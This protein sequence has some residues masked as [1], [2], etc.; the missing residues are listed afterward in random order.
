MLHC[1][2]NIK[3]HFAAGEVQNQYIAAQSLGV[4]YSLYTCFPWVERKVF[5][6]PN[7]P[8]MPLCWQKENSGTLIPQFISQTTKHTIQDSGL[9]T[10]MFGSQKSVTKDEKLINRWYDGLVEFTLNHGA[11]VTCVEVDCQRVLSPAKAWEF[12]ER[13]RK[14]LP[15]QNRIINVFH[16]PDGQ[17]GLD[18]LIEYSDYIAISVPEM[19]FNGKSFLVP[20]LAKYIKSKK[21]EIDIHLLGC[22]QVNLLKEC[23][24]CTSCD[25]TSFIAGKRFG[26]LNGK[27][28]RLLKRSEVLKYVPGEAWRLI[29]RYNSPENTDFLCASVEIHKEKYE[30]FAGNQDYYS[31]PISYEEN[32]I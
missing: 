22:T 17:K 16:L 5:K 1:P 24:F 29:N 4:V 13:L 32:G 7:S 19:R 21:P 31:L 18:R 12:R 26:F 10:L 11:P 9:F 20:K 2:D 6:N 8:I 3:V 30:H 14:D 28:I 23:S 25:S 15:E 27:H